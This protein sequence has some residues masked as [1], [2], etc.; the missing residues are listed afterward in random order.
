ASSSTPSMFQ[1]LMIQ[2]ITFEDDISIHSFQVDGSPVYTNKIDGHFKW[3]VDPIMCDANCDSRKC[4]KV[5]RST[6]KPFHR[7][8]KSDDPNSHWIVLHPI[9]TKPLPIYD[10]ALQILQD[11]GLLHV[12]PKTI[13]PPFPQHVPCF[14]ASNY[15]QDFP[16]LK[17]VSNQE[18]N[19]FSRPFIQ[20]TE[21]LPDRSLKKPSQAEW[22]LN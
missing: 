21:V 2:P 19:M 11:E 4:S 12:E 15:D 17:S 3:D 1:S 5:P 20:S 14:I 6:C 9:K 7:P 13:V 8:Y 18:K 16:P 10:R 22:V